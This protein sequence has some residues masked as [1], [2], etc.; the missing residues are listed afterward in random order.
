[1]RG[2]DGLRRTSRSKEGSNLETNA[3]VPQPDL[4]TVKDVA[5]Y[6]LLELRG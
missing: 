4:S 2:G 6:T 3:R 5:Y 1:M